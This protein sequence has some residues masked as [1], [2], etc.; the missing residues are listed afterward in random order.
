M[1]TVIAI[2]SHTLKC[3]CHRNIYMT[4][5]RKWFPS[6]FKDITFGLQMTKEKVLSYLFHYYRVPS[7][8]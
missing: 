6:S 1:Q 2:V 4:I 8:H 3:S 5:V 7:P